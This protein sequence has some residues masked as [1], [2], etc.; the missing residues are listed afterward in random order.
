MLQETQ[1]QIPIFATIATGPVGIGALGLSSAGENWSR[2]V[3]EDKFYGSETS[4]LNKMLVSAGYG[5]AE[6]VFDRYLTLPI[7]QR[8][9]RALFGSMKNFRTATKTGMMQYTKQFGKRQLIYDPLLETTSE[10]LTTTFQNIITGRPVTENLGHALFSGG[11]FGTAFGH[12]PFYK[13]LVM[14]KFS[15]YNS[16]SSFRTNLNKIADLQI[17]AK[18][19]NTSLKANK[20]KGNDTSAIEGNIETVNQEINSLQQENESTIKSVEKK[21]NNLSKKWFE[22]YNAATVAQEQIRIDVENIAKDENLSNIEKQ[23]L[24]NI[25]HEKFNAF[26][27]TRDI[28]RDDKNFGNAYAA[29]RNS[30]T[31]E[32]QDRLQEISGQ[33]SSELINEGKLNPTDDAIDARA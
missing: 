8:S 29:F 23:N 10:G 9:G 27:Q 19:L 15:D 25:K 22:E 7:M 28:L 14:Q 31:K 18:K 12:V 6:V 16:Y 1:N 4:L 20:T 32:D 21:T 33:A 17:T 13:G 11:M 2:M 24:I 3:Q 30:N 5:A 26:Q